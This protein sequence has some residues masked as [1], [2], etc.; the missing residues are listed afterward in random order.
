VKQSLKIKDTALLKLGT[1]FSSSINRLCGLNSLDIAEFVP[2]V[3]M[4]VAFEGIGRMEVIYFTVLALYKP[5]CLIARVEEDHN[6]YILKG[7]K[8]IKFGKSEICKSILAF[9][10]STDGYV[11]VQGVYIYF[12]ELIATH[13]QIKTMELKPL[14]IRFR[15]LINWPNAAIAIWA[16]KHLQMRVSALLKLDS[17]KQTIK[18]TIFD[19]T[20]V[21]DWQRRTIIEQTLF[22]Y[23]VGKMAEWRLGKTGII[24]D[25]RSIKFGAQKGH[26]ENVHPGK[27]ENPEGK[28]GQNI[29]EEIREELRTYVRMRKE[30]Q[31][32]KGA[33]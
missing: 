22:D 28:L 9:K 21:D 30:S 24:R 23:I 31:N 16:E 26:F 2:L 4:P 12:K 7:G 6:I 32:A 33:Q 14:N 19:R 17:T 27:P 3:L 11:K 25:F 20:T 18:R 8:E 10:N 29:V 15:N 13:N 1:L 5:D